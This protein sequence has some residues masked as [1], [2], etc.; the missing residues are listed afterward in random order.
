MGKG[1]IQVRNNSAV[2]Q[3]LIR[4]GKRSQ[5]A[6]IKE[7]NIT[8]LTVES[9]AKIRVPVDTGRLRSSILKKSDKER[10]TVSTNVTYAP[11][12][13]FGTVRMRKRPYLFNSYKEELP[14]LI[15]ESRKY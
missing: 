2:N 4:Y 10:V 6:V 8:G 11:F 12:I 7:L 14:R 15:N 1:L 9:K 5:K 13:E 3:E